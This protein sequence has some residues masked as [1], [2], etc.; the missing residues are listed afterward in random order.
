MPFVT[1]RFNRTSADKLAAL[2]LK[3]PTLVQDQ[4]LD[5]R[6]YL[7][8]PVFIQANV[9]TPTRIEIG[10]FTSISGG[11]IGNVRMGRYCA[12]APHV[13]IGANEHP[14]DWLTCSRVTY[15]PV[16][17]GWDRF[18]R[19]DQADAIV[20]NSHPFLAS[21]PLTTLGND[22]WIGEG[23]FIRSGITLNTGCIVAAR[24]VVVK[25]VPPYAIVAGSP[26]KVK[27]F[28]FDE[29]TIERLL[30][31]EWWRYS[32]Y[33]C[34]QVPFERIGEALDQ[35]EALIAAGAIQPYAP[36]PLTAQDLVDLFLVSPRIAVG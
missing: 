20:K 28:R 33:D 14:T 13:M 10:A 31:L 29:A 24:S 12:V 32:L 1:V 30:R 21:A 11:Q 4:Q 6:S 22:V 34:F 5:D 8:P 15:Y 7:E 3:L 25:D 27:R 18:C 19:G 23:A 35:L 17:H 2:G 9:V 36:K 16:V 26:A